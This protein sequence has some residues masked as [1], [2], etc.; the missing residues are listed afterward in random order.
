MAKS[1]KKKLKRPLRPLLLTTGLSKR[2]EHRD[3]SKISLDINKALKLATPQEASRITH[4][5]DRTLVAEDTPES[6]RDKLIKYLKSQS[7]PAI[8]TIISV[9]AI[10]ILVTIFL[11][12]RGSR[13]QAPVALAKP[14]FLD[15]HDTVDVLEEYS[16][17]VDSASKEVQ[18]SDIKKWDRKMLDNIY[19][20]LLYADRLGD[21]NQVNTLLAHLNYASKYGVN[22]DDNSYGIDDATREAISERAKINAEKQ[23]VE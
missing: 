8:Y 16:Q 12:I 17:K 2:K 18:N 13:K 20:M 21:F 15:Q 10:V 1:E 3:S 5:I 19:L 23:L 4:K 11:V 22:I 6:K 9:V 7:K 14:N